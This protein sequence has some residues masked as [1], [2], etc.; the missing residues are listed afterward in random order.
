MPAPKSCFVNHANSDHNLKTV[1][2]NR[3]LKYKGQE[4]VKP[5]VEAYKQLY[6]RIRPRYRSLP[7]TV[8]PLSY[9]GFLKCYSGRRR[10]RYEQAVQE[11]RNAPLT[12]EDAVVSTFIKNEKFD[13]LQKKQ[14]ADPRAIQPRKPKYLAEVGRW[15]K[16]LEHIMYKD[17][18]KRLYGQ[19]ALPCIAK[20]LN[21][22]ETAEV[23][24]TKW[25]KFAFPVCVSLD[26]SR[27]DL[28]VSP[29]ALRFTHRL[30]H[31]YCQSRQL[32]KY[33]EWTLRNAGVASCP[34][35]AYQYEVDG[36]RMS[37]DMDTA[38]GNCVLMLCLTWNFL[39][40]HNIKHEI[41]DNGDDCLFICEA[42]DVPTDKQIMDYYLDFGFVV[43][44]EGKVSVFERIEF[45]QTSPVLTANGWRMVRNLKSIAKDLCN[46]NMATGS[47]SEYTSW[48]KAVGICGRILNDGVP[49]FSAFHNML[50]RHGTNSRIERAVFW[51]CGLTNL[52]KG[53]SFEQLEITGAARESFYLA[54]GIPPARQLAIEAYY[55]SLQGPVGKI[56][57]HEWPLQLKEEYACG[58]EWFEGD[59]E[60]A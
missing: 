20:G 23:L 41:M 60:R 48:L 31:K 29:D 46:V 50:V 32:R 24:R 44:L 5:R 57:L 1:M 18:A 7:D 58:A 14:L 34:E 33:L 49:I 6:E 27:F 30:Y 19:D 28:H 2:M 10:T 35:S 3:V 55:D 40:Q 21:A 36:R 4:P 56:Q 25:E 26:A 51:E 9:D 37:G 52:I 45:C 17:L 15:F 43:R 8:Y 11:L 42:A 59:D 22:R 47:L 38:L 16:P 12:P 54:Y 13:W 39:D 53:M